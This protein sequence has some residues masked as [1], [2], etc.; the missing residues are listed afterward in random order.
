M[1][2]LLSN[3]LKSVKINNFKYKI[4]YFNKKYMIT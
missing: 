2:V 3:N 1:I 4:K